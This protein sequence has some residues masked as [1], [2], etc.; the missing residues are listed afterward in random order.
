MNRFT[1]YKSIAVVL[2]LS[3][4]APALAMAQ[5]ADEKELAAYQ[6]TM[7]NVRKSKAALDEMKKMKFEAPV[8]GDD[9]S[10]EAMARKIEQNP[11]LMGVLR[12]AGIGARDFLMTTT[13]VV[14]VSMAMAMTE[15]SGVSLPAH[16][17]AHQKFMIANEKELKPLL[18]AFVGDDQ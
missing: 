7:A 1:T 3:F 5:D 11:K 15:G 2:C 18:P 16:V 17:R 12:T 10:F 9:E 13:V 14:A 8:K 6:L 4:F